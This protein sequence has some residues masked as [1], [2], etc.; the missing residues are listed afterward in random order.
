MKKGYSNTI[1]FISIVLNV[2]LLVVVIN[3]NFDVF[4]SKDKI[5]TYKSFYE[6]IRTLDRTLDQIVDFK[7]DK[8]ITEKM[9][10]SNMYLNFVNDRFIYFEDSLGRYSQLDLPDIKNKLSS[11]KYGY[12]SFMLGQIMG[13]DEV[14][15]V[16]F[17]E[18]RKEI[19]DFLEKLPEEYNDSKAFVQKFNEAVRSLDFH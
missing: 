14:G 5:T 1:I 12:E 11:H 9:Y 3:Q 16:E 17:K 15:S 2:V 10:V 4:G 18:F 8:K 13:H 6:S 7:E 19:K